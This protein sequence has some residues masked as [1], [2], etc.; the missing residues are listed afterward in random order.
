MQPLNSYD[1]DFKKTP[2]VTLRVEPSS[3]ALRSFV[4]NY[5]VLDFDTTPGVESSNWLLSNLGTLWILLTPEPIEFVIGNRSYAMPGPIVLVGVMSRAM[6]VKHQRGIAVVVDIGPLAWARLFLPSAE[7][8]RDRVTLV[9]QLLPSGWSE[10][11]VPRLVRCNRGAAVKTVIDDFFSE[12]IP[13]AHQFEET[14]S[15]IATFMRDETRRDLANAAV[16]AG[17][18][19]QDLLRLSKRYFGFPPKTM[20][21]R[22]RFMRAMTDIL[23]NNGNPDFS[24][25]P[26]GY[27]DVRHFLRDADRF[28]GMT[29]RRFLKLI[30]PNLRA[31]MRAGIQ[32][33]D[34]IQFETEMSI[35]I[36][37]ANSP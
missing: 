26:A 1:I 20:M 6:V 4:P 35:S 18:S 17:I 22:T 33:A 34:T 2:G 24:A 36:D 32:A 11:L 3:N 31:S 12:R 5:R 19:G 28:L 15:R 9:D 30:Q 25:N 37:Y 14:L 13:P 8:L 27:H 29:P 21:I 16:S 7:H 10:D 23:V